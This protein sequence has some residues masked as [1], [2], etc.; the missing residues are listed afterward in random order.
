MSRRVRATQSS[1]ST[2]TLGP[3]ASTPAM[4]WSGWS[5]ASIGSIEY[6]TRRESR[7]LTATSMSPRFER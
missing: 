6:S 7:T 2:V 3:H 4:L 1:T 5:S